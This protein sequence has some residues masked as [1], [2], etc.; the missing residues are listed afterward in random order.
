MTEQLIIWAL[1]I[2]STLFGGLNIFQ[3]LT[4]RSYKRLKSA[5]ADK[6]E[7]ENL[8]LT[9]Q[10]IQDSMQAEIHRL[11]QR[12]VEAERIA[13]ENSN[14]YRVLQEEFDKYKLNHK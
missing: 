10:T 4:L 12:V 13:M 5:E 9:I 7:I 2:L 14:K 1:G 3:W 8:R 11:Q 6:L